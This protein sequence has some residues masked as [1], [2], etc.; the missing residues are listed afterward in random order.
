MSVSKTGVVLWVLVFFTVLSIVIGAYEQI[1]YEEITVTG[2]VDK[3]AKI[4]FFPAIIEGYKELP[5]FLNTIIFGILS[6]LVLWVVL[7]TFFPT[8]SGGS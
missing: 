8:G 2:E 5:I 7:S 1:T 3:D 4:N 6:S